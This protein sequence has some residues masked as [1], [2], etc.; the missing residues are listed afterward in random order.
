MSQ[1]LPDGWQ[2]TP[3]FPVLPGDPNVEEHELKNGVAIAIPG[4]DGAYLYSRDAVDV[5][6][7]R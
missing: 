2:E 1:S 7:V 3:L 5:E 6:S 4:E